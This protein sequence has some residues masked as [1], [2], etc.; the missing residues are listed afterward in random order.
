MSNSIMLCSLL[1]LNTKKICAFNL[2]GQN[3]VSVPYP[4]C[5]M[6]QKSEWFYLHPLPHLRPLV[7]LRTLEFLSKTQF[8]CSLVNIEKKR[9]YSDM[10]L[11]AVVVGPNVNATYGNNVLRRR[12]RLSS[13]PHSSEAENGAA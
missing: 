1:E 7:I 4:D 8:A 5:C 12:S 11:A 9:L 2:Q 10:N 6:C 3:M 13:R